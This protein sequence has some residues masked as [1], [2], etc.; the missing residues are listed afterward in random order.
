M[1]RPP[2]KS[3]TRK[4]PDNRLYTLEVFIT[5]GPTTEEFAEKNPVVSRTIQIRGDQTLEQLHKA[6]FTAF[7][8]EDP[9]MYE[10]QFGGKG[11][12]DPKAKRYVMPEALEDPFGQ[13]PPAGIVTKTA[14]GS[15][16]LKVKD[17]FGYWFDFGDDWHHQ[18]NVVGIDDEAPKG[19]YPKLTNRVGESPPQY[20]DW[21]EEED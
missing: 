5:E 15:L 2:K 9:H 14:I 11:P 10:F 12:M 4:A 21:E 6:I 16:G 3:Q 18:I 7:D 19:R 1:P 17:K 8:R 20:V 13:K